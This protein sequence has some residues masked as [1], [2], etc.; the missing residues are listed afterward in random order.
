MNPRIYL[1]PLGAF[2]IGTGNFVFVGVLDE[3]AAGVGVRVSTAGQLTTVFA[4]AYAISAPLLVATTARLPRRPVL[5]VAL[6]LFATANLLLAM[7]PPFPAM[8]ALR[9]LAAFGAALY[10]PVAMG[11]AVELVRPDERG[12]AMAIVLFGLT[13]AFLMGIPM[14]TWIGSTFGWESTF[15]FAAGIGGLSLCAIAPILPRIPGTGSRGLSGIAVV[16]RPRV[17]ALLAVSTLAFVAVFCI[18][19]FIGP[20]LARATGLGGPGIAALQVLLGVGGLLGVPLGG[21]LADQRPGPGPALWILAVIAFAQSI[22]SL[23]IMVPGWAETT[24]SVV[25]SGVALTLASGALFALGPVQQQRLIRAA[26]DE[27]DIVLSLNAAA[28]FLGQGVGAGIGG[29][30][31]AVLGFG[32][33]GLLGA[34]V[35]LIGV[36]LLLAAAGRR[37]AAERAERTG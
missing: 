27:R 17:A 14:G 32:A 34:V 37:T 13:F 18:N 16:L 3:L 8:L 21:W 24:G 36:V 9:V 26:D 31:I 2:A 11:I 20:V 19:A 6:A 33:N 25:A 35:A 29:V 10:M 23:L 4:V 15:A 22:F 5:L 7:A 28:L 1:L 12:R 30:S